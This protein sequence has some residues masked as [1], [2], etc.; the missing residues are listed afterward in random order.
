MGGW[1]LRFDSRWQGAWCSSS[2]PRVEGAHSPPRT[3]ERAG[4]AGR[5]APGEE[6]AEAKAEEAEEE[7]GAAQEVEE[8][9]AAQEARAGPRLTPQQDVRPWST[10]RASGAATTPSA[11]AETLCTRT[12]GPACA[13]PMGVRLRAPRAAARRSPDSRVPARRA[14]RRQRPRSS[15]ASNCVRVPARPTRSVIRAARTEGRRSATPRDARG[16]SVDRA[17]GTSRC[18][19]ARSRKHAHR[20][21]GDVLGC[22]P[23]QRT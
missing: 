8:T 4:A 19:C 5:R 23:W 14:S 20:A 12:S 3:A 11:A 2:S 16:R 6:R 22:P 1:W 13:P 9:G 18:P 17:R 7:T 15:P 10:T 21:E